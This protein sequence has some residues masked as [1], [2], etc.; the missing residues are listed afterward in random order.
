MEELESCDFRVALEDSDKFFCRHTR[1]HSQRNVVASTICSQCSF[2]TTRCEFPRSVP[3]SSTF[4]PEIQAALP[5]QLWS[6]AVAVGEFI[7]DGLRL[8]NKETYEARLAI[9]D[10]CEFRSGNRCTECG[11]FL[12]VKATARA[13]KCPLGKW[14][15]AD[16]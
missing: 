3:D 9:C 16:S 4:Q 10:R 13:F 1:V 7:S 12:T 2:R 14:E 5:Q 11:C 15:V 6:V 8:T